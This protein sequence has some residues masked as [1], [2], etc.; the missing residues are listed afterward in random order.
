MRTT[1]STY[2]KTALMR[3]ICLCYVR[4]ILHKKKDDIFF[5]CTYTFHIIHNKISNNLLC[6]ILHSNFIAAAFSINFLLSLMTLFLFKRRKKSSILSW[7]KKF[8]FRFIAVIL[9]QNA[10]WKETKINSA[11]LCY[12]FSNGKSVIQ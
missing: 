10:I 6:S 11:Y 1:K 5:E 2:R 9:R 3:L 12:Q 8:L 4:I 7:E